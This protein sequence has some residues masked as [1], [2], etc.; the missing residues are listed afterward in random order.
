MTVTMIPIVVAVLGLVSKSLE[1]KT[2]RTR[3]QLK[4]R[5]QPNHNI[6]KDRLE[7]SPGDLRKLPVIQTPVKDPQ[8][9][10]L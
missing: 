8:Q 2:E 3:N 6:F 4:N 9:T 7:K 10:L 1:K 5:D